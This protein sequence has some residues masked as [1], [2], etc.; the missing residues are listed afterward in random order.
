M[1]NRDEIINYLKEFSQDKDYVYAMWLE[2]S[3][4]LNMVDE[5]SDIDFWFDVDKDHQESFLYECINA[6]E[7][8]GKIDSRVDDIRKNIAESDIHLANTNEFLILDICIQSHEIRGKEATCYIKNDIAELPYVIFDKKNIITYKDKY[9]EN[10]DIIKKEF[11]INKSKIYEF[12]RVKKYIYRNMY[13]EAYMKYIETMCEPLIKIV[14]LIYTPRH[15]NYS[16]CH[17]SRHLP[18]NVVNELESLYK[19]SSLTDINNNISIII[20]LLNKYEKQLKE[21]YNIGGDNFE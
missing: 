18:K 7:K 17:I 12:S 20:D 19:V 2:G 5:Y 9:E 13:L 14:R 11:N 16:L 3:D 8:I 21:K 4:G 10:L 1:L 6:L 15:Y